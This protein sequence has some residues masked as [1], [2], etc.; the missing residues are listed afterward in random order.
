[1]KN[2]T[3][4]AFLSAGVFLFGCDVNNVEMTT[5][6]TK[7]SKVFTKAKAIVAERMR[8]PEATRFKDGYVAYITNTGDEIVCGTV[9][10]KNAMG[11]YV[12]YKT[13][14]IRMSGD[15]VKALQIPSENDEYNI[16]AKSVAK[17]CEDAATGKIMT[18]G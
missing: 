12:G 9:N 15:T 14:Y 11:G 13:F 6:P 4:V 10:A 17:A 8:D 2:S 3:K 5:V 16:Q 1:M 18:M 7:S